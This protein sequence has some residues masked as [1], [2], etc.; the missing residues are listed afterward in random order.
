MANYFI[1]SF[2]F[3]LINGLPLLHCFAIVCKN[4]IKTF[5]AKDNSQQLFAHALVMAGYFYFILFK[6]ATRGTL[7]LKEKLSLDKEKLLHVSD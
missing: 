2:L 7:S 6:K 5:V 3:Y 1:L 4:I